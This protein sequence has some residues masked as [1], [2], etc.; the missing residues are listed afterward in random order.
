[1]AQKLADLL[2]YGQKT[3]RVNEIIEELC[4]ELGRLPKYR[5]VAERYAREGGNENTART[6]YAMW[7]RERLERRANELPGHGDAPDPTA[8]D[9]PGDCD[10]MSLSIDAEGRLTLPPE[11]RAAMLLGPGG[12]VVARVVDGELRIITMPVAI[13]RAQE[14]VRGSVPEGVSL[15]DELIAERRAEARREDAE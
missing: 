6:Q 14:F 12:K 11:L 10:P 7:K 5:E 15:A 8:H 4:E 13:R 2:T 9:A 3:R 1:M